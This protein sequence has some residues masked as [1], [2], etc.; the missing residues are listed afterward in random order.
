M[1]KIY[2][3]V[4][5]EGNCFDENPEACSSYKRQLG[6]PWFKHYCRDNRAY[7]YFGKR[8]LGQYCA[9]ECGTC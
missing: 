2:P 4:L 9:K 3:F 7:D 8:P 1:M 5:F 6:L